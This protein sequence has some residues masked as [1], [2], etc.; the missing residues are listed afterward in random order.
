[1][2]LWQGPALGPAGFDTCRIDR[3]AGSFLVPASPCGFPS[4][5][6]AEPA[7]ADGCLFC[8]QDDPVANTVLL[9]GVRC[10]VRLD[11]YPA[12]AG[13]VEVVPKRHVESYFDLTPDE[14]LEMHAL[15]RAVRARFDAEHGPD[16]YT[17]GV[18]EGRAAGRTV[19]HVHLH[20]VPRRWGDVQDPRGGI[21][22]ALPNGDPDA[23][24]PAAPA[25]AS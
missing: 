7:R 24:A 11:N 10:F 14:V 25:R 15:L 3:Q 4:P 16:G 18:N 1:M 13:H 12:T 6:P 5:G 20:L 2:D 17:I 22:R 21:R 19:D 9:D 8:R 23:W